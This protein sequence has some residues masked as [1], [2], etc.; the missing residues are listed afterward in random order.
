[1]AGGCSGPS[2]LKAG[3]GPGWLEARREGGCRLEAGGSSRG[4]LLVVAAAA[5]LTVRGRDPVLVLVLAT[6][7]LGECQ[8]AAVSSAPRVE[9][10]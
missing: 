2:R 1:M 6:K 9:L 3:S 7:I 5:S 4:R 10:T 8:G